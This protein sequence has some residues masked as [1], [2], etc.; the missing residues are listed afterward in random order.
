MGGSECEVCFWIRS[1]KMIQMRQKDIEIGT[2]NSKCKLAAFVYKSKTDRSQLG[3]FR[4][5]V[6]T[7]ANVCP[8]NAMVIY[9][10]S[11]DWD[12]AI[13]GKLFPDDIEKRA[14]SVVKWSAAS[15]NLRPRNCLRLIRCAVEGRRQ[16]T[17][18]GRSLII[19]AGSAA[20]HLTPAADTC[21]VLIKRS[22]F[23]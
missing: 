1:R 4:T 9:F 21:I 8:A 7:G 3:C 2:G 10:N 14:R 5:L 11:F 22:G 12:C 18:G 23:Q 16:C 17:R 6:E 20:G 15:G 19:S 13:D